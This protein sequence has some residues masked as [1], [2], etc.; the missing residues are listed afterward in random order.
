L[1]SNLVFA[2]LLTVARS[3]QVNIAIKETKTETIT[4]SNAVMFTAQ[5]E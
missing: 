3:T 2:I 1:F 4:H 5:N